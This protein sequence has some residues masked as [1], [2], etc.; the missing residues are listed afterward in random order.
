MVNW[1]TAAIGALALGL[2]TTSVQSAPAGSGTLNVRLVGQA[3][4]SHD[5][6]AYKLCWR[7]GGARHCRWVES[8]R[9]YPHRRATSASRAGRRVYGYAALPAITVTPPSLAPAIYGPS[10]T[11]R[12]ANWTNP[13]VY[14]TGSGNWW[15][16]MD[17][18]GRGGT[19]TPGP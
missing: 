9:I 6:V 1:T 18:N 4:S 19:N 3:G 17:H 5:Q 14:P 10:Y 16:V 11:R 12:S 2:T 7:E 13:D 8:A 15:R